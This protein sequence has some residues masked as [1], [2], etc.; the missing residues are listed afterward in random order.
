MG[1][2]SESPGL[3]ADKVDGYE[4]ADLLAGGTGELGTY[5]NYYPKTPTE[6]IRIDETNLGSSTIEEAMY[7]VIQSGKNSGKGLCVLPTFRVYL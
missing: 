4:A 1:N 5:F 3:N 6:C 2:G 7:N